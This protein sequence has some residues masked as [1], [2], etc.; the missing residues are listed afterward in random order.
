MLHIF[1]VC[2]GVFL[3]HGMGSLRS[4]FST[5]NLEI[6]RRIDI[7]MGPSKCLDVPIEQ[8]GDLMVF[9]FSHLPNASGDDAERFRDRRKDICIV[10]HNH[11]AEKFSVAIL[12]KVIHVHNYCSP[13]KES[14][15]TSS[16]VRRGSN[17]S[18]VEGSFEKRF[19][20]Y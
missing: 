1:A 14:I 7:D 3:S 18:C 15:I 16:L 2:L 17:S 10:V 19:A 13:V 20:L 4:S 8:I 12:D 11:L 9:D 6:S 5:R